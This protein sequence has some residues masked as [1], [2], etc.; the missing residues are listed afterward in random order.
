ML[1]LLRL[2]LIRTKR[3]RRQVGA[4]TSAYLVYLGGGEGRWDDALSGPKKPQSTCV[5]GFDPVRG[6]H[7]G[8]AGLKNI[9]SF[10]QARPRG[11]TFSTV[12]G[13]G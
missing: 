1:L 7:D 8:C 4:L 5:A 12:A 13:G 2:L 9:L 11:E 6:R 3:L 10:E